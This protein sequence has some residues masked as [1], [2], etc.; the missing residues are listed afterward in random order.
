ME[1]GFNSLGSMGGGSGFMKMENSQM[2]YRDNDGS[3]KITRND[4]KTHVEMR[5][6]DGKVIFDGPADTEEE[7]AETAGE[8][9]EETR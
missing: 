4:G 7:R 3:V 2:S 5:D 9:S 6:P 8:G 1:A